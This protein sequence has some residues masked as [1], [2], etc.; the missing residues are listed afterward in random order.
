MREES[1]RNT[2]D[3]AIMQGFLK[4]F[5]EME[6][7]GGVMFNFTEALPLVELEEVALERDEQTT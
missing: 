5:T 6:Q 2:V 3:P 4:R 1:K 7:G